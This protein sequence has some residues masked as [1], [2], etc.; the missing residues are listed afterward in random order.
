[1]IP[2]LQRKYQ[3]HVTS[4]NRFEK[5]S[6]VT[7]TTKTTLFEMH[8]Y[9]SPSLYVRYLVVV[10]IITC[11]M[12]HSFPLVV[13]IASFIANVAVAKNT[14]PIQQGTTLQNGHVEMFCAEAIVYNQT[15]T[16]IQN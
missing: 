13:I 6:A 7:Q 8:V 2:F 3:R 1:M 4:R 12:Y 14:G 9:R 10:M 16:I 5:N 11:Q 15:K